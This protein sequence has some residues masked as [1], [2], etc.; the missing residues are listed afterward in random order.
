MSTTSRILAVALGLGASLAVS[1]HEPEAAACGGCFHVPMENTQVASH[2]MVMSVSQGQ[3]TLYDEIQYAGDPSSFAWV[4]PI[5]GPVTVALS[6]DALFAELDQLTAVTITAPSVQC[7]CFNGGGGAG[8]GAGGGSSTGAGGG[9]GVTIISQ[10]VVGPYDTVQLSSTNPTA[11]SDWLTTNGYSV[12]VDI[13]PVI[14]AYVNGGFDFLAMKL[15]PGMGVAAMRPVSVTTPGAS[16]VLPLRMVAAGVGPTVPITLFVVA[17]GRY[18]PTNFPV[19][20]IDPTKVVWDF[21]TESSNYSLLRQNAFTAKP[22]G[23]LVEYA[24]PTSEAQISNDIL[25]LAQVDPADSGYADSMG[26]GAPQAAQTDLDTLFS[27]I[28]ASSLWVTRFL[29]ELPRTAL[30]SDLTLG[31]SASQSV[32]NNSIVATQYVNCAGCGGSDVGVGGSIGS[33][34]SGLGGS[35]GSGLGGSTGS[36]LGGTSSGSGGTGGKGETVIQG[37]CGSCAAGR[38]VGGPLGIAGAIGALALAAARK[39]RRR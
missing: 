18:D 22:N 7:G 32:V 10:N 36:G 23:W 34:G 16:P 20:T 14:A 28:P 4:L 9:S 8:F 35:T 26:N 24:A 19:L 30:T 17:E 6:S 3:S 38:D 29:A 12:P 15:I 2:R 37:G 1:L 13:Q 27:G 39:R 25:N 33:G 21:A 11:R 31:A 5:L